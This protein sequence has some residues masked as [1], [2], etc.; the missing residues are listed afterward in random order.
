MLR[1]VEVPCFDRPVKAATS[2]LIRPKAAGARQRRVSTARIEQ[3]HRN[4]N[5]LDHLLYRYSLHRHTRLCQS[6]G[7]VRLNLKYRL[8]QPLRTIV[9][10]IV[11]PC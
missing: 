5:A 7:Q 10:V 11:E 9:A 2:R 4:A 1:Y 3:L 6:P 8:Q